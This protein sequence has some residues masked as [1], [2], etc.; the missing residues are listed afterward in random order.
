MHCYV[1]RQK[2]EDYLATKFLFD[3]KITEP[4]VEFMISNRRISPCDINLG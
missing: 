4:V 2:F 1:N 3:T